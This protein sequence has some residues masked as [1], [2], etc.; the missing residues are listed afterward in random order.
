MQSP[1]PRFLDALSFF[2]SEI[3]A[4]GVVVGH[5]GGL[6]IG[7]RHLQRQDFFGHRQSGFGGDSGQTWVVDTAR[8]VAVG[9]HDGLVHREQS[10]I[11]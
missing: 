2:D 6:A 7:V 1:D 8:A 4:D 3:A 10:I 11:E 5:I 9:L